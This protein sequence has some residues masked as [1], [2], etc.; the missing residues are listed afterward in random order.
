[1]AVTATTTA[2]INIPLKFLARRL[3]VAAGMMI[4]APINSTPRYR[5]PRAALRSACGSCRDAAGL[6][7]VGADYVRGT[8]KDTDEPPLPRI[9]PAV[10]RR[11][12]LSVQRLQ[13]GGEVI[14]TAKQDRVFS[15][16]TQTDG[17]QLLRLFA[18]YTFGGGNVP[19]TITAGI[20]LDQRLERG[21]GAYVS[22]VR[23]HNDKNGYPSIAHSWPMNPCT[24]RFA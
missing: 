11:A 24:A 16:E 5:S 2:V 1:V 23:Q 6:V 13:V 12:S 20:A 22:R 17:Y 9:P 7:E 21:N 18:A 4:Y 8:V 10:S 15:T 3:A 19:H 14:A